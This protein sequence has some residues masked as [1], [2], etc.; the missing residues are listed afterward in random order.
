M[1]E[2]LP[3][4]DLSAPLHPRFLGA[5]AERLGRPWDN[6]DAVLVGRGEAGD[7]E[8]PLEPAVSTSDHP[9]VARSVEYRHDSTVYELPQ[10]DGVLII[11]RGLSERWEA[12]FEVAPA[13]RGRGLGR[14]L[15][16]SAL[17]LVPVGEPVFVQVAPGNVSS[18]RAVLAGGRVRADRCRGAVP[19]FGQLRPARRSTASLST[20]VRLQNAKRTRCRP[21]AGSS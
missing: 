13:A 6:L 11:G 9:R 15:V 18:L 10:R 17:R 20:S 21:V 14:A 2:M 5:L 4:G 3:S 12:A 1:H 7:V 8:L 19:R 16:R